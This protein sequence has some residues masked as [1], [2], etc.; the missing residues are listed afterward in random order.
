MLWFLKTQSINTLKTI[1]KIVNKINYI[2]NEHSTGPLHM[3]L[4]ATPGVF[5]PQP[6]PMQ[7]IGKNSFTFTSDSYRSSG[8]TG[9]AISTGQG[10]CFLIL[11]H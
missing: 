2:N 8:M 1:Y 9:C 4:Y 10:C 7:A 5:H 6:T 11:T 3:P